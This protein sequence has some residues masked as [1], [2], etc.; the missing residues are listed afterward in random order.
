[1]ATAEFKNVQRIGFVLMP[2]F[3]LMSYAAAVE[4]LRAANLIAGREIYS[5]EVFSPD[6][7]SVLS[8]AGVLVP[9]GSLPKVGSGLAMVFVCAGGS[10]TD[11]NFPRVLTSL[12]GLAREGVR[13]GGI[14]GGP[15]ILAQAGLLKGREFTIHWEH[16]TAFTEA[17]PDLHPRKARFVIDGARITCGGGIAP[18]DMMH[19]LIA[20]RM[21][22][23]FARRVSDWYLHTH[24]SEPAEPQRAS[25]VERF[26]V[27]H[28]VLLT[29][30]EKME[31]TIE[32]PLDRA[33]MARFAGVSPRHLDRLF[34]DHMQSTFVSEYRKI[35]LEHARRLLRQSPLTISE[36][37]FASGFSSAGHFSRVYRSEYGVAPSAVRS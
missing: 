29:V 5:I 4:P 22:S 20:E 31:G 37:A 33:H 14:S 10:P 35:R 9:A 6:A 18:L 12:R 15:Y 16:E 8:S 2:G 21:G 1:M 36:I 11:W 24:V 32:R 30:L 13:I 27:H 28:P 34:A 23:H 25:A 17:F 19:A 3:A 7:H 26:G